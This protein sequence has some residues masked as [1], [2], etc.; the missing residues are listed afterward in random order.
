MKIIWSPIV[1]FCIGISATY[2]SFFVFD[3]FSKRDRL[4]RSSSDFKLAFSN[5]RTSITEDAVGDVLTDYI[6]STKCIDL[7]SYRGVVASLDT[8]T[9]GVYGTIINVLDT[10]REE[11]EGKLSTEYGTNL[12]IIDIDES[13]PLEMKPNYWVLTFDPTGRLRGV[14]L[15]EN[16]IRRRAIEGAVSS[17]IVTY[18]MPFFTPSTNEIAIFKAFPPVNVQGWG[19]GLIAKFT[20]FSTMV[21]A[22]IEIDAFLNAGDKRHIEINMYSNQTDFEVYRSGNLSTGAT[23]VHSEI[24]SLNLDNSV[25]FMGYE[26]IVG[27]EKQVTVIFFL[28]GS[29]ISMCFAILE[30]FRARLYKKTIYLAQAA[31]DASREKSSFVANLS[32]EIR[33]PMNG[34][35][36]MT[37]ILQQYPLTEEAHQNLSVIKSCGSALL[38]LVNNILDMSS[39]ESGKITIFPVEIE[40]RPL[41]LNSISNCWVSLATK[42]SP[43]IEKTTIYVTE[44]VP[45]KMFL[46]NSRVCQ[47]LNNLIS[48]AYKYTDKGS[49][50]VSIDA[51][52]IGLEEHDRNVKIEIQVTDT[53]VGMTPSQLAK[54]F[55]PFT[56]FGTKNRNVQGTGLGLSI[57][58]KISIL[59][60]GDITCASEHGKGTQFTF[61]FVCESR[62]LDMKAVQEPLRKELTNTNDSTRLTDS[63][64]KR[65]FRF[66]DG[67]RILV[68]DDVKVN[69]M[70]L[71]KMIE[72]H[73]GQVD[74]VSDGLDAVEKCKAQLYDIILIDNFMPNM[75]GIEATQIIRKVTLN[76]KTPILFITADVLKESIESFIECGSNDFVPKPFNMEILFDKLI[77]HSSCIKEIVS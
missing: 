24:V 35:I 25:T 10:N 20:R 41:F 60:G 36:G 42:R 64:V 12:T 13:I 22:L 30:Y 40:T 75:G 9:T 18:S 17:G 23:L 70:I 68:A 1:V 72:T 37:D 4:N 8:I 5:I 71:K 52:R 73:G 63:G 53:G 28:I 61:T 38:D 19:Q 33:T 51:T 45:E 27:V 47:V 2:V 77:K 55:T 14:D 54:L 39:I 44:R 58:K 16:P 49:I 34:I 50:D 29:F 31:N 69:R 62:D 7:E 32:H 3:D 48:N 6:S 26:A 46:D 74:L 59:M 67:S 21:E 43:L 66:E 57:A 15:S 65:K 11:F 76:A 56:R